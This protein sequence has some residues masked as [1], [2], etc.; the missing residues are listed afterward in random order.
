MGAPVDGEAGTVSVELPPVYKVALVMDASGEL[1]Y[2][3]PIESG[4]MET[5]KTI[6]EHA[7]EFQKAL[8]QAAD[9]D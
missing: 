6:V 3:D 1:T 5:A 4:I 2:I 9:T 8:D 7:G